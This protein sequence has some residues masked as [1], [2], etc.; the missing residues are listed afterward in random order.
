[1]EKR[2]QIIPGKRLRRARSYRS[3]RPAVI[4][5]AYKAALPAP[6]LNSG[7]VSEVADWPMF[8]NASIGDCTIAAHMIQQRTQYAGKLVTPTNGRPGEDRVCRSR[9][10]ASSSS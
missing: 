1:M 7:Y 5:A 2:G 3:I 9:R 4:V 8:L 10:R 6:P